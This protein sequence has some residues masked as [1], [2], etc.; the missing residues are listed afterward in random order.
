MEWVLMVHI[1][2]NGPGIIVDE[3]K[4][5]E[6]RTVLT[7]STQEECQHLIDNHEIPYLGVPYDDVFCKQ[8]LTHKKTMPE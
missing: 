4:N 5:C 6:M 8:V 3:P 7:Y 1:A 2:C